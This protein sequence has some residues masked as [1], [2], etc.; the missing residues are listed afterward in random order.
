MELE[1]VERKGKGKKKNKDNER[2]EREKV[3]TKNSQGSEDRG[4]VPDGPWGFRCG[5]CVRMLS[6]LRAKHTFPPRA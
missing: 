3:K 2:P 4:G 6:G 5:V 1:K